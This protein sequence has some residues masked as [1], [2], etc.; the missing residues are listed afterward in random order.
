M[1]KRTLEEPA[2]SDA[3]YSKRARINESADSMLHLQT[4]SP[5]PLAADWEKS[6]EMSTFT[7]KPLKDAC[8]FGKG[9]LSTVDNLLADETPKSPS[10]S[11]TNRAPVEDFLEEQP[12]KTACAATDD[13][14]SSST[15]SLDTLAVLEANAATDSVY[16]QLS[17]SSTPAEYTKDVKIIVQEIPDSPIYTA[18][19]PREEESPN[20]QPSKKAHVSDNAEPSSPNGLSSREDSVITDAT[21]NSKPTPYGPPK[22]SEANTIFPPMPWPTTPQ[23]DTAKFIQIMRDANDNLQVVLKY[24]SISYFTLHLIVT[25]SELR[26]TQFLSS[27][28]AAREYEMVEFPNFAYEA[29]KKIG[30]YI[31]K[32]KGRCKW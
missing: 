12:S 10:I 25:H 15:M 16:A 29:G 24:R 6:L 27:A 3:Q 21:H 23:E 32:I 22:K 31:R 5:I 28:A 18:K 8:A 7:P 30:D 17:S 2:E 11:P 20:P 14:A 4:E 26:S 9:E 19:R 13:A 1:S